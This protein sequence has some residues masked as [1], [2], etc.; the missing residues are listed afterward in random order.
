M[1]LIKRICK[2]NE[3]NAVW[4]SRWGLKH[5]CGFQLDHVEKILQDLSVISDGQNVTETPLEEEDELETQ[6]LPEYI[7]RFKVSLSY[8]KRTKHL[9][10]YIN[11]F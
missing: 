10:I 7:N 6:K 9:C 5:L 8:I 1:A 4:L 11:A 2:M 3:C